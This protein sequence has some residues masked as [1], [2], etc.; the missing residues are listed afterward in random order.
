[1]YLLPTPPFPRAETHH[2]LPW[3]MDMSQARAE[4]AHISPVESAPAL[5][6]KKPVGRRARKQLV[7]TGTCV[8]ASNIS[9]DMPGGEAGT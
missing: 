1:M 6:L 8:S 5:P 4:L 3:M 7:S 2:I 9:I